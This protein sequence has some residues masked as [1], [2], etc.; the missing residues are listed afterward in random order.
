MTYEGKRSAFGL[1]ITTKFEAKSE[2]FST[3]GAHEGEGW[4]ALL[5]ALQGELHL[6]LARCALQSQYNLL[7]CLRLLV[8]DGLGLTTV[9]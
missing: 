4:D 7:R 6:V 1:L 8:E 2:G 3:I 5:A 9:S